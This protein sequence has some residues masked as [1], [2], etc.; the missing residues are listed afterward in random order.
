MPPHWPYF[1]TWQV[2]GGAADADGTGVA[3]VIMVV[4]ATVADGCG[5]GAVPPDAPSH[6]GGPG[7]GYD[8]AV[9]AAGESMLK[10]MPGS[11]AE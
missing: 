4:G 6:T 3:L 1:W 8:V 9:L 5:C 7:T 11:D 10:S 2:A